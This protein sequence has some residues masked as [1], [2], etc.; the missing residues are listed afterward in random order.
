[1]VSGMN[2]SDY[3]L[4][5]FF[6]VGAAK[7][8]TTSLYWYLNEH[9]EIFMSPIK[10]P[11]F[12][13]KDFNFN[14]FRNEY[15]RVYESFNKDYFKQKELKFRHIAYIDDFNDYLKLFQKAGD[16]IA[17]EAS[18]GYLYSKIAANEMKKLIPDAKIIIVLRDPV[19]RAYSHFL[20]K[21]REGEISNMNFLEEVLEDYNAPQKGWGISHLYVELGLYYEQV[22]RFYNIFPESN[23][24]VVLFDEFKKNEN[25]VCKDIF[26]FL[27]VN[28]NE[29]IDFSLKSNTAKFPKYPILNLIAVKTGKF[30][31]KFIPEKARKKMRENY[32]NFFMNKEKPVLSEKDYGKIMSFF[33]ED[34]EKLEQLIN[35][36]LSHWYGE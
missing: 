4:P 1:M 24:K 8:G 35:K 18:T 31:K 3:K 5:D 22:K 28:E 16:R 34:L 14:L 21:L 13:S 10:E 2:N 19:E 12:F 36:D 17:G 7:A 25:A 26:K 15:K 29:Y 27:G 23:I 9:P 20:M 33:I 11:H 6:I 30:I 32:N